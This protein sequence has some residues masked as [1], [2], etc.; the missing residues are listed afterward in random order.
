VSLE[1]ELSLPCR[2]L[3]VWWMKWKLCDIQKTAVC[4]DKEVGSETAYK[5]LTEKTEA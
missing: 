5:V 2:A 4:V 1:I 3:F